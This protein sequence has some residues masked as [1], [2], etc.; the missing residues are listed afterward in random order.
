[1]DL[2]ERAIFF[3]V[4]LGA[5][6][7]LGLITASIRRIQEEVHVVKDIVEHGQPEPDENKGEEGFLRRTTFNQVALGILVILTAYAAF[8]SANTSRQV[9]QN[10]CRGG[11]E[12]RSVQREMVEAIYNL[13]TGAFPRPKLRDEVS[14]EEILQYNAYVTR[15]NEFR[16]NLYNRIGPSAVCEKYVDDAGVKPPSDPFPLIEIPKNRSSAR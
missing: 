3:A 1:M 16:I 7:V 13:A 4:G 11:V 10:L 15:V 12:S 8:T 2:L 5:G 14:A 6:F 9:E